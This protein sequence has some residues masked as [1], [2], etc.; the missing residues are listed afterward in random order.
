M[1]NL[2][3]EI[4]SVC[5]K[6]ATRRGQGEEEAPD[7][8]RQQPGGLSGPAQLL[9][10]PPAHAA[11][12]SA[13]SPG[14]PGPRSA[15]RSSTSRVCLCLAGSGSLKLTGQLGSVMQESASAAYSY[16]R[17]RFGGREEY[18]EFFNQRD[19]HI[20]LPAG[21]IPKDGPSAGIAMASVLLSLLVEQGHRPPDGHDRRNHPDRCGAAHRRACWKR[22]WPPIGWASG[23]IIIPA[24]NEID[25]EEIPDEVRE[26]I[27][28]VPGQPR[29]RGLGNRFSRRVRN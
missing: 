13:W 26:A 29:G 5:R 3:R 6:V 2:E 23:R 25:L 8:R 20:H 18:Q 11:S 19:I 28:F 27:E 7:H 9:G 17:N 10:R 16:L 24:A 21:A 12:R 15:A 22:C 1:R 4:G 14:W